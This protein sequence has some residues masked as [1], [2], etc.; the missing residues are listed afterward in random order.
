MDLFIDKYYENEV[1]NKLNYYRLLYGTSDSISS[2]TIE[3]T[4]QSSFR[5][6][7]SLIIVSTDIDTVKVKNGSVYLQEFKIADNMKRFTL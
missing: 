4:Y 1:E 3:G 2:L 5:T 6:G 7:N